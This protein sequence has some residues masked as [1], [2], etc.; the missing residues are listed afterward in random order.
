MSRQ[1]GVYE[2]L[3]NCTLY[4]VAAGLASRITA[5]TGGHGV[6]VVLATP[7]TPDLQSIWTCLA[8]NGR[9]VFMGDSDVP[10]LG[11]FDVSIFA[12]GASFT[13]FDFMNMIST[14]VEETA[15]SESN[16]RSYMHY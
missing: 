5:S 4:I 14:E 10:D 8:K 16:S 15:R 11:L 6:D 7:G 12:K 13:S 3:K 9:F 2:T 1:R